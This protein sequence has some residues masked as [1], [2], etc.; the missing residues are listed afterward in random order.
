MEGRDQP[1]SEELTGEPHARPNALH[2]YVRRDLGENNAGREQLSTDIDLVG[3]DVQ[4][5]GNSRGE[6]RADI[7]SI[8]LETEKGEGQGR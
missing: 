7:A 5:S 8:H 1:P 2:N 4:V 6:N 3:G